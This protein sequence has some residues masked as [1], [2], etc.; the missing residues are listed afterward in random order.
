M[1]GLWPGLRWQR[2]AVLAESYGA[3]EGV[4]ALEIHYWMVLRLCSQNGIFYEFVPVSSFGQPDAP[5]LGVHEIEAGIPYAI[6]VLL[7]LG[8]WSHVVGDGGV[9]DADLKTRLKGPSRG[10]SARN[11]I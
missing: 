5:R 11:N 8:L 6:V 1:K 4:L 2:Y 3:S 10:V 9:F 7:F